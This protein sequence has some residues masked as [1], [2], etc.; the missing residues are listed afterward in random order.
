[1]NQEQERLRL[2]ITDHLQLN[3]N[4][5]LDND[6]DIIWKFYSAGYQPYSLKIE[7][8]ETV[9]DQAI[10][11]GQMYRYKKNRQ[12]L[13]QFGERLLGQLDA[14]NCLHGHWSTDTATGRL[15]CMAPALQGSPRKVSKYF[16]AP[17]GFVRIIGD[18]SHIDLRVLAQLSQ[19][20]TLISAFNQSVDI[21][22]QTASIIFKKDIKLIT[23]AERKIGK[24]VNFSII[25]GISPESLRKN[26]SQVDPGITYIDAKCYRDKFFSTYNGIVT[27]QNDI[28]KANPVYGLNGL[29]WSEFSSLNCRLNY[30]VQGSA[31]AGLKLALIL[32]YKNLK[33]GWYISHTV[34]DEI[35]IVVPE[36][37]AEIGQLILTQSM[38]D[39][40]SYLIR[41][42]PVEV[43]TEIKYSN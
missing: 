31:A 1:M 35:Q 29:S 28:L 5:S 18:Y 26:L 17:T 4:Q 21:H 15:K 22:R 27:W 13:K 43:Q 39:G 8:L 41:D 34:H 37:D 9:Q 2:F 20:K 3:R 36:K 33:P 32:L 24:E 25:Y 7:Y 42:L 14:Q 12:F 30:P 23:D 16:T 38:I 10:V 6:T 19:D 40:M 11:Y